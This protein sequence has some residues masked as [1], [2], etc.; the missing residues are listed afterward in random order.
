MGKAA[1]RSPSFIAVVVPNCHLRD[2]AYL[3]RNQLAGQLGNRTDAVRRRRAQDVSVPG[4]T[5]EME[6]GTIYFE[7][8]GIVDCAY[9]FAMT[10]F[11][12]A[13]LLDLLVTRPVRRAAAVRTR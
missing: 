9:V 12:V 13:L 5:G 2:Y 3:S 8:V 1:E 4:M 6:S 10:S 7:G 11:F